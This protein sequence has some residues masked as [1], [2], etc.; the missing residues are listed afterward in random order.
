MRRTAVPRSP[1]LQVILVG[2]GVAT[3]D[4]A[5]KAVAVAWLGDRVIELVPSL[6]LLL[7]RNPGLAAGQVAAIAVLMLLIFLVIGQLADRDPGAPL[8]MGLLAGAAVGNLTSV[9][10]SRGTVVDFIEIGSARAAIVGNL[11]DFSVVAGLMLL[12]RTL[13]RLARLLAARPGPLASPNG[14]L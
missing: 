3:V 1:I 13:Y 14:P 8:A 9:L 10:G 2:L 4:L 12:A 7:V 11:A 6:R 5:S